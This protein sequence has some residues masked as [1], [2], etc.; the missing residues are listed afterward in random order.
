MDVQ[1]VWFLKI[2][3]VREMV[4]DLSLVHSTHIR[5]LTVVCL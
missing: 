5:Y 4:E 2:S 1:K 3:Q